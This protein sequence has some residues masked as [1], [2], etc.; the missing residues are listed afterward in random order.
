M[1]IDEHCRLSS[2]GKIVIILLGRVRT[3]TSEQ[4]KKPRY[5][6]IIEQGACLLHIGFQ[7]NL[8]CCELGLVLN[9]TVVSDRLIKIIGFNRLNPLEMQATTR[10]EAV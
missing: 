1:E 8:A 10:L 2:L 3:Q 4:G 5:P 6:P 9:G 7:P